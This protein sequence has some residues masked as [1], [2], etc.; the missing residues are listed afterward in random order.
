MTKKNQWVTCKIQGTF[1]SF[2]ATVTNVKRHPDRGWT[3]EYTN[4]AGKVIRLWR[5]PNADHWRA[6]A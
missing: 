3:G 1:V 5:A 2:V 6:F 4:M